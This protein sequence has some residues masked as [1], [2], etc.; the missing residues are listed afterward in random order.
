M[1]TLANIRIWVGALLVVG[2]FA[3][4]FTGAALAE[5]EMTTKTLIDRQ[6]ILDL[7]TR[8]YY[9]FGKENPENFSDFY[10]D[11]AVLILGTRRYEGKTGIMQAYGRGGGAPA[12]AAP[13][14]APAAGTSPAAPPAPRPKRYSFN[15]TISNPLIVVHGN[16]ATA[17]IIFTEYVQEKQGDP[18]KMTTQGKEYGTFV[19]VNGQWRYRTRQISGGS[20]PP[21][22]WKE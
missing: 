20:E 5:E 8:Y 15:V 7:I 16:T 9:N 17:Q 19:R 10:A 3:L 4:T 14:T 2:C 18:T 11:D 22:D 12:G 1:K 21:A 13:A 6:Q